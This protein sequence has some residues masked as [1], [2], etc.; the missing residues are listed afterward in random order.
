V[1]LEHMSLGACVKEGD[2]PGLQA[3]H[4]RDLRAPPI[5]PLTQR[6]FGGVRLRSSEGEI[7]AARATDCSVGAAL[8]A[9]PWRLISISETFSVPSRCCVDSNRRRPVTEAAASPTRR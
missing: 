1:S 9:G 5:W 7:L 2:R 4:T 3:G 6:R 8:A